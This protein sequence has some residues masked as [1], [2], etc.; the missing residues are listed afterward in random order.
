MSIINFAVNSSN[1][2]S[3]HTLDSN[4]ASKNNLENGEAKV[5]HRISDVPSIYI[6]MSYDSTLLLYAIPGK[7]FVYSVEDKKI[8]HTFDVYRVVFGEIS[9]LNRYLV[10][11]ENIRGGIDPNI[12]QNNLKFY[13]LLTGNVLHAEQNSRQIDGKMSW[14]QDEKI[15]A[16]LYKSSVKLYELDNMVDN[17]AEYSGKIFAVSIN[18]IDKLYRVAIYAYDKSIQKEYVK[19]FNLG[20]D[21][22]GGYLLSEKVLCSRYLLRST[23]VDFF[24][25]E[26]GDSLLIQV[27][28]EAAHSYNG[29]KTLFLLNCNGKDF[30]IPPIGK[31]DCVHG[32][33]WNSN[34]TEFCVLYGL[35]PNV[36]A[37]SFNLKADVVSQFSKAARNTA[38]YNKQG[39][40]I[41]FGGI[42]SINKGNVEIW[43]VKKSKLITKISDPDTNYFSWFPDGEHFITATQAPDL[44]ANNHYTIWHYTGKKMSFVKYSEKDE[45]LN[46]VVI[47]STSASHN[48][49]ESFNIQT[50]GNHIEANQSVYV[51]QTYRANGG[52]K[53]YLSHTKCAGLSSNSNGYAERKKY[54]KSKFWDGKPKQ[55]LVISKPTLEENSDNVHYS[56]QLKKIERKLERIELLK[57]AVAEGKPVEL[58][59]MTMIET[60]PDLI[61][62]KEKY[63]TKLESLSQAIL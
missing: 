52:E 2:V 61:R 54:T 6:S 35:F 25:N 51:P 14:S 27:H 42:K 23:K 12:V 17:I 59:Q 7:C 8:L 38:S 62:K 15:V 9:N 45:V 58:N 31:K 5:V 34:S 3:I 49:K 44:L 55:Q 47:P 21:K 63:E 53:A 60:E 57:L 16:I 26:S 33:T 56:K 4:S 1:G 28:T 19:I 24:W 11:W 32:V 13:D 43:D 22:N 37:T 39:N 18:K 30:A 48:F 50:D 29:V 20:M 10:L 40:L 36:Q 46:N 41:A